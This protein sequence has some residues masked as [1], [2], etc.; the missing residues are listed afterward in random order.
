[1]AEAPHDA[2]CADGHEALVQRII[3]GLAPRRVFLT[4]TVAEPLAPAFKARGV[5]AVAADTVDPLAAPPGFR[6]DL[7]IAG[8]WAQEMAADEGAIGRLAATA[9]AVVLALAPDGSA[10]DWMRAFGAHGLWPDLLYDA[11]F[12]APR[13]M[14]LRRGEA[15]SGAALLAH[16]ETLRLRQ[17]LAD[18]RA[19]RPGASG[20]GA[21]GSRMV[22]RLHAASIALGEQLDMARDQLA[23]IAALRAH[24]AH[25]TSPPAAP[26][27]APPQAS[28]LNP[29]ARASAM[30]RGIV[31]G[32]PAPVGRVV[33]AGA[34]IGWWAATPHRMPARLRRLR[35]RGVSPVDALRNL[36]APPP[37]EL[38]LP[39]EVSFAPQ[40][41]TVLR[42]VDVEAVAPASVST[43]DILARRL[44][45]LRPL[46]VFAIDHALR[47]RLTLV[48]DSIA[49]DSFFGGVGTATILA[50]L[51]ARRRGAGLR[52]VTLRAEP[53]RDNVAALL[54]ALGVVPPEHV[55]F[56]DAALFD[57]GKPVDVASEDMFLTTSWWSTANT[58][59][60]IKPEKVAYIVQEDERMFYPLGDDWLRAQEVMGT[61]G[62]K[63]AVNTR[64]LRDHLAATGIA[65]LDTEAHWFE[66]AFPDAAYYPDR[67][68]RRR[69]NF[70]FYAR[71]NNP[72]NLYLR[73]MEALGAAIGQGVLA[74]DDWHFHFVGRELPRLTLPGGVPV[75]VVEGLTWDRYVA[76]MRRM[77]LGLSLMLTPHPS[78]P[79]LDLVACG[80]VAVTNRFGAKQALDAYSENLI[81]T[82]PSV[83][84]LV[85]GLR[86]GVALARDAER[87]AANHARQGLQRSW[88]SAFAS[89]LDWLEAG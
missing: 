80:A 19:S 68:A 34:R 24:Y 36:I 47:P 77:D 30:V 85:E 31:A 86:A 5:E 70:F 52:I 84:A 33:V 28:R 67:S 83:A 35:A 15:P 27:P 71:P 13:A 22:E 65:G 18:A 21:E 56:R 76:M 10:I 60:A 20:D 63:R 25:A 26:P 32:M 9:E 75:T 64:L 58:L 23:G 74:P 50:A 3:H 8:P 53:V 49:A 17:G 87:R 55:E 4:G 41:E 57:G 6:H 14:L 7:V 89:T 1:M 81:C 72:R 40:T 12:L 73:G 37:P 51:W 16:A 88:T 69:M 43:A 45:T 42:V 29:T 78:Y 62:L 38:T 44:D 11:S 54:G 59:G 82:E 2:T 39:I 66:P 48:T 46:P 79:P 61:P